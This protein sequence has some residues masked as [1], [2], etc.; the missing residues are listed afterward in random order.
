VQVQSLTV[1][2]GDRNPNGH[3]ADEMLAALRGVWGTRRFSFRYELLDSEH[4]TVDS[5]L[6]FVLSGEVSMNW[7]ADIKRTA[8]FTIR[9]T[10]TIDYLSDRIR[11]HVRVHLPPW[12]SNDYMEFPQGV[13]LLSTPD[14]DLL[15]NGQIVREVEA[16]DQLQI[17]SDDLIDTRYTLTAGINVIAAV[18]TLLDDVSASI[19]PSSATLPVDKEWEPGTSK[20]R[21]INDLLDMINYNSLSF[22]EM[23]LAV[24][25]LYRAPS[26]RAEEYEYATDQHSTIHPETKQEFDLF[27]VPNKI[28]LV[29]SEVDAAPLVSTYVNNDPGSP[30]STVNRGRTIV[31]YRL[32]M[33]AVDQA[34]LDEK[35][36]RIAFEASQ[37]FEAIPFN[38]GL[39]P[40]HSGND[41]YRIRWD[42]LAVNHKYVEQSWVMPLKAGAEM[43]HRARRV[44]TV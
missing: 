15:R 17:Y 18:T 40:I 5:A 31:D 11:P 43:Q 6:P 29:Y 30:T 19:E 37:V 28:V 25:D 39:M 3:T 44:V 27:S 13:F 34:T 24:I 23:G 4:V 33:E 32:E 20:L 26:D 35:A 10:G 38:T 14:R 8:K 36:A 16:Y 41:V 1:P 9:E 42:A 2:T 21:I 12:E 7:L 22:D